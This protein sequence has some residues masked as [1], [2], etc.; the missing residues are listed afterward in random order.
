MVLDM[1]TLVLQDEYPDINSNIR[2]VEHPICRVEI[3]LYEGDGIHQNKL[4]GT[5][6]IIEDFSRVKLGKR[7]FSTL[8]KH[9]EQN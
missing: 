3:H 7:P 1:Q 4:L 8:K 5:P 2:V 9:N 6:Q